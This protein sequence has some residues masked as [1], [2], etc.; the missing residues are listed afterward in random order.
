[1]KKTVIS[2]SEILD[3]IEEKTGLRPSSKQ[4]DI[5]SEMSIW[6]DDVSELLEAFAARY[7]VDMSNY[8][9]YFHTGDEGTNI[10]SFI[11]KPPNQRVQRIPITPGLLIKSAESHHWQVAYPEHNIP[12]RRWDL[13]A[14]WIGIACIIV[15][16]ILL[17]R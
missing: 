4:T 9:W 2:E 11:F 10:L 15:I 3:F 6:G 13:L 7:D 17:F 14:G 12:K 5:V 1:M 16:L 8:L